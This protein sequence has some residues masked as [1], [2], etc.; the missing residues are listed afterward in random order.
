[1]HT[2]SKT[3]KERARL[4]MAAAALLLMTAPALLVAPAAQAD[5]AY[6][7]QGFNVRGVRVDRALPDEE[8]VGP[9]DLTMDHPP[10]GCKRDGPTSFTWTRAARTLDRRLPSELPG[11]E[12]GPVVLARPTLSL[13]VSGAATHNVEDVEAAWVVFVPT[14]RHYVITVTQVIVCPDGTI[15]VY[16]ATW[17]QRN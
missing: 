5:H 17:Y 3:R 1:M 13:G 9:V 16:V 12:I 6:E 7:V 11:D 4:G 10:K 2:R 15:I 14:M 8:F